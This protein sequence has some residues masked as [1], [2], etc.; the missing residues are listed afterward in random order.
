LAQNRAV[1][2]LGAP[3]SKGELERRLTAVRSVGL[4]TVKEGEGGLSAVSAPV[5]DS[6][7]R[8]RLA[9]T[10]FGRSGRLD[11]S[12]SGPVAILIEKVARSLGDELHGA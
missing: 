10:V 4:A 1:G 12:P 5:F 3:T 7:K 8:L 2:R 11:I 9:L 6:N